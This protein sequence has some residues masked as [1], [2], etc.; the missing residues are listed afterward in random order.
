MSLCKDKILESPIGFQSDSHINAAS[1]TSPS[2]LHH[3]ADWFMHVKA[4]FSFLALFLRD[5]AKH[6]QTL[7]GEQIELLEA[8]LNRSLLLS[9]AL[10]PSN[11][12]DVVCKEFDSY[13]RSNRFWT[14]INSSVINYLNVNGKLACDRMITSGFLFPLSMDIKINFVYIFEYQDLM[15]RYANFF[16]D[17]EEDF[18]ITY[19]HVLEDYA[20]LEL[21]DST[22]HIDSD[23]KSMDHSQ[24][25]TILDI[26]CHTGI[27]ESLQQEEDA[28]TLFASNICNIE[29]PMTPRN[30]HSRD[31]IT[32]PFYI[33]DI[34]QFPSLS[35]SEVI[36]RIYG[37]NSRDRSS[38]IN[39]P[40]PKIDYS[41]PNYRNFNNEESNVRQTLPTI[42]L[43]R[44]SRVE[45]RRKLK[46]PDGS[47]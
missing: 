36:K 21:N 11:A 44:I 43:I 26:E 22:S 33:N 30:S 23:Q 38:K 37:K 39:E 27:P 45:K 4:K 10:N 40:S 35:D 16:L 29:T 8:I 14:E 41:T 17:E 42:E 1:R 32:N 28:S 3:V 25:E 20:N 15:E 9:T 13:M 18:G 31:E 47:N 46:P 2:T 34:I 24:K 7:N 6:Y 19:S 12:S 5:S